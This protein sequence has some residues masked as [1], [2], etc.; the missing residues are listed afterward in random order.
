MDVMN[1]EKSCSLGTR[2][3]NLIYFFWWLYSFVYWYLHGQW[4]DEWM[5]EV[6]FQ[7]ITVR[8]SKAAGE[9]ITRDGEVQRRI[10]NSELTLKW[11]EETTRKIHPTEEKLTWESTRHAEQG[12][13]YIYTTHGSR[14]RTLPK[15]THTHT[16]VSE[17]RKMKKM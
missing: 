5:F 15:H 3:F 1:K 6:Y 9:R 14:A 2:R 7:R 10:G 11:L 8:E 13:T 12:T 17:C 16:K 4:Q